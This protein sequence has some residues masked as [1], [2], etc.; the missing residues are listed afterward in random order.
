M[1]KT[2]L[3]LLFLTFSCCVIA[4]C[5][6]L[7]RDYAIY[8]ECSADPECVAYVQGVRSTVSG[9]ATGTASSIPAAAPFTEFIGYI[10][11]GVASVFA[12]FHYGKNKTKKSSGNVGGS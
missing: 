10:A 6:S 5:A 12:V 11:A 9:V 4:G 2:I 3:I 1:R 7:Q 8:K